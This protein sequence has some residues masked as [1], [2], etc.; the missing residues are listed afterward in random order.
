MACFGQ[1]SG[2]SVTSYYLPVMVET[3]GIDS[4]QT[5]LMLN[6]IYPAICLVASVFGAS[7]C[8]KIGRRPQLIYSLIFCS[9]C[10]AI[11]TATSKL[12]TDEPPNQHAANTMIAFIYIFGAV[13]SF[14][15]TGLQSMYIAE[16]LTTNTRAKGT[17][18]GNF[19]TSV[20]SIIIQ[21]ASGPAF[22]NIK[23]YFYLV[24]VV[25]D[26]IEVVIMWFYFPETK[27]RT[28]E[29]LAEV[30]DDPNPV[31]RSLMKRDETTVLNTLGVDEGKDKQLRA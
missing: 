16:T 2:N 19:T 17:A 1:L 12:A 10:F 24:F 25:W 14:G 23:Y 6:G 26:L 22:K 4:E 5:Q 30:F 21:Y 7:V 18:V 9:I 29:E 20:A 3:A 13:F 8:D 27:E 31:K 28:L 11:M 15:W